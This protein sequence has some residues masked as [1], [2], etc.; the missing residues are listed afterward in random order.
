MRRLVR[1]K[2]VFLRGG[3]RQFNLTAPPLSRMALLPGRHLPS[4]AKIELI[5]VSVPEVTF[6]D[7]A[8]ESESSSPS[9]PKSPPLPQRRNARM[10]AWRCTFRYRDPLSA[11]LPASR[12]LGSGEALRRGGSWDARQVGSDAHFHARRPLTFRAA[13]PARHPK[14]DAIA[15]SRLPQGGSLCVPAGPF[16]RRR[17]GPGPTA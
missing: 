11:T 2:C 17:T 14:G 15:A 4:H 9:P 12:A 16:A 10:L 13:H 8:T 3:E 7:G 5:Q 1:A 6:Q